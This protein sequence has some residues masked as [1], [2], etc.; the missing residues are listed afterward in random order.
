[1]TAFR[2]VA[3]AVVVTMTMWC[4]GAG[5]QPIADHLKCYKVKDSQAKATYTA[6]LT[7]LTDEPGCLVKVPGTLLCV[8][9]TKTDV[10]PVPPGGAD[11]SGPAGR[12]MCH[13]TGASTAF[14]HLTL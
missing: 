8:D 13:W 5:A 2:V 1:M 14:G 6:H 10:T 11:D 7:G 9:T 4:G 3:T 12:F